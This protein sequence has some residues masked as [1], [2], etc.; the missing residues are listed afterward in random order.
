MKKAVEV[1]CGS[2]YTA[3]KESR[4]CVRDAGFLTGG[5]VM[6]YDI[7]VDIA[8]F[9]EHVHELM[10]R[11]AGKMLAIRDGEVLAVGD[12]AAE[13]VTKSGRPTGEC[14]IRRCA[15]GKAAHTVHIRSPRAVYV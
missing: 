6:S 10:S 5:S 7:R 12:T 2:E 14:L 4:T 1:S 9:N 8:W 15:E 13:A 11:Y 3:G